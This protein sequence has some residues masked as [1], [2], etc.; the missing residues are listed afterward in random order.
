MDLATSSFPV[1]FSP[2][3][4]IHLSLGAVAAICFF[5]ASVAGLV[6][7]MECFSI[8]FFALNIYFLLRAA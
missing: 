5:N 4:K 6:P 8:G 2:V 1:P 7:F 3:M